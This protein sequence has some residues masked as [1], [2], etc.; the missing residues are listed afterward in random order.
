MLG[1]SH[2]QVTHRWRII[3]RNSGNDL[4]KL[5]L[6]RRVLTQGERGVK[7][8]RAAAV[9]GYLGSVLV[10]VVVVVITERRDDDVSQCGSQ[11]FGGNLPKSFDRTL[12]YRVNHA[13]HVVVSWETMKLAFVAMA[14]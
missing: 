14:L 8:H 4:K 5:F 9:A 3:V 2:K 7:A 1:C 11:C 6:R 12:P 10:V 13:L